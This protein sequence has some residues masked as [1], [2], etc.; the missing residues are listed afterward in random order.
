MHKSPLEFI[1]HEDIYSTSIFVFLT[2]QATRNRY[3]LPKDHY[4]FMFVV[5]HSFMMLSWL[6][7]MEFQTKHIF[8]LP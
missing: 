4:H 1:K 6:P 7:Q 2:L 3:S 5:L 8:D